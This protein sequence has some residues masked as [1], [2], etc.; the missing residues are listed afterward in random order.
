MKAASVKPK[1]TP[2]LNKQTKKVITPKKKPTRP[3]GRPKAIIDY[4][5]VRSLAQIHC[6]QEEI[7]SFIEVDVRT[8]QRDE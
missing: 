2:R 1:T 8:L 3:V 7:A 4:N 6:T 5:L